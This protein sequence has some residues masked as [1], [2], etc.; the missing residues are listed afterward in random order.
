MS[1]SIAQRIERR[2][3]KPEIEVQL[4]MEAPIDNRIVHPYGSGMSVCLVGEITLLAIIGGGIVKACRWCAAKI[5]SE[6]N[7]QPQEN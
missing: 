1:A 6:D 4:F 2:F 5:R 3:P 7:S